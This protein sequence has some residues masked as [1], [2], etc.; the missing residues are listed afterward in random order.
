MGGWA[1]S[2]VENVVSTVLSSAGVRTAPAKYCSTVVHSAGSLNCMDTVKF[3]G[4][5]WMTV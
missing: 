4:L 2:F 5:E 3:C 1:V